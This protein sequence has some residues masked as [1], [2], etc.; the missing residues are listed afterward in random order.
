MN[1]Q[2]KKVNKWKNKVVFLPHSYDKIN[3]RQ[4]GELNIKE[5]DITRKNIQEKL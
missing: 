4:I 5:I 2:V 1:C 3:Y